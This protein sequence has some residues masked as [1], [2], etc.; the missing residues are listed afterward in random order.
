MRNHPCLVQLLFESQE[1]V[2][3]LLFTYLIYL[4]LQRRK[5]R[6]YRYTMAK[7]AKSE[8]SPF[9]ERMHEIIFEADTK[10]GKWFDILL[11]IMI[12][13]SVVMVM[14]ESIES[15]RLRHEETLFVIE[16]IFTIFFTVEYMLRLYCVHSPMKYA[17]SFFGIVDLLA[18]IPTYLALVVPNTHFLIVVRA[19]R[20]MRVFR[21]FKLANFLKESKYIVDSLKASRQKI[22]VFLTFIFLLTIIIGSIMYLVEG[23]TNDAFSS[24]PRSI[25]WAIVTL[26]TVGYGDITPSTSIGQFFAAAVMI[27]GYA[28]IAVPTG[29]VSAEMVKENENQTV[30]LNTQVCSDCG[31]DHHQDDA[32]FCRI[33]GEELH[34]SMHEH[35][36]F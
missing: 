14:L 31:E 24:I 13:L 10:A 16:W 29:I 26:T 4:Y 36:D 11:M 35:D 21:I 33:C 7:K 5:I 2:C 19:L 30:D 23:G 28:V 3:Y 17:T 27:L 32:L 9:R 8:F 22:G 15:F 18:I 1:Q 12:V 6:F 34:V 25:Y 20:L